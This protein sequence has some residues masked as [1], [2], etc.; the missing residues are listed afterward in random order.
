V[1]VVFVA[2]AI[3]LAVLWARVGRG[4]GAGAEAG[5]RYLAALVG[6]MQEAVISTDLEFKVISW[7]RGAEQIYGWTEQEAIGRTT[8][9][10][11]GAGLPR[12][13]FEDLRTKV[14]SEREVHLSGERV[15][16][17]G[18]RLS[19]EA[20]FVLLTDAAGAPSG[21][22]GVTRDVT[23]ARLAR[24]KIQAALQ[25]NEQLVG[26]LRS[27]LQQVKTLS[28]LLPICMHCHKVR[29]DRGYWDRID[30]YLTTH[31]D[32]MVSHGLCPDCLKEHYPEVADD[33]PPKGA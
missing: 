15:R 8:I 24:E 20:S 18:R 6:Q 28:G 7:S 23:E 29:N 32:A 25:R 17:D 16:K 30:S 33:E 9:E 31:T 22:L 26:E 3:F 1:A 21:I 10:L 11:L 27:T 5:R 2:N 12:E 4:P 19:T 14:K 13:V